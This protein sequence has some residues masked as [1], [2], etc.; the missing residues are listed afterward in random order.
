MLSNEEKGQD[1]SMTLRSVTPTGTEMSPNDGFD[2][3]G[4]RNRKA[5]KTEIVILLLV[6]AMI[7]IST[8]VYLATTTP[9]YTA[10]VT[11]GS[12]ALDSQGSTPPS[13]SSLGLS[14]PISLGTLSKPT[15]KYIYIISTPSFAKR[16]ME[17]GDF[18]KLIFSDRWNG[19]E[20]TAP[21]GITNKASIWLREIFGYQAW[22]PPDENDVS[23]YL[24]NNL[25][26]R[27]DA[28]TDFVEISF[29]HRDPKIA[30]QVLD[31]ITSEGDRYLKDANEDAYQSQVDF[32]SK[33][34][35]QSGNLEVV[36]ALRSYLMNVVLNKTLIDESTK[37]AV[38]VWG[39]ASVS[40]LPTKPPVLLAALLGLILGPLL[41]F[42]IIFF[43]R[44]IRSGR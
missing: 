12:A 9:K 34:I 4:R 42:S 23:N 25:V 20:W 41:A 3:G 10:S 22:A 38:R 39:S 8:A 17:R 21:N 14:L 27:P 11:I 40:S 43:G 15:D 32:I 18:A 26:L 30:V 31:M 24:N 35:Q 33:R 13:M 28:N 5:A 16:L 2:A 1:R 37:Y 7:W 29:D 36:N 6:T 19:T 44:W